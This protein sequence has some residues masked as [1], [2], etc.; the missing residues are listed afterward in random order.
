VTSFA[1]AEVELHWHHIELAMD[2]ILAT[3]EGRTVAQRNWRPPAPDTNSIHVLAVHIIGNARQSIFEAIL[4]KPTGRDRD[5]EFAAVA[6]VDNNQADIWPREKEKLIEALASIP[7]S[8]LEAM[9][10][11][12]RRGERSVR[13]ILI[14]ISTHAAE[15]AGH[16]ELTRDMAIAA[17]V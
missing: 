13:D 9:R 16:V 8:D 5:A 6:T 15:H 10:T 2:R 4:G 12:P 17:G 11:H 7:E 1:S 14:M 3:N